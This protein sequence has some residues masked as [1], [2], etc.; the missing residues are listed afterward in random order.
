MGI[1]LPFTGL[2]A[3][4]PF[5]STPVLSFAISVRSKSDFLAAFSWYAR[6]SSILDSL[7]AHFSM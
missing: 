2:M 3:R 6:I 1:S 5:S 4:M 7:S